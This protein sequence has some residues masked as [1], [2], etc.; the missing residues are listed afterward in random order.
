MKSFLRPALALSTLSL[1]VYVLV[2]DGDVLPDYPA[3]RRELLN[4]ATTPESRLEID[5]RGERFA[6]VHYANDPSSSGGGTRHLE[7]IQGHI[8]V[9]LEPTRD[10]NVYCDLLA[11]LVDGNVENVLQ[12]PIYNGCTVVPS[13]SAIQAAGN[14]LPLSGSEGVL[15]VE[16]D[17]LVEGY[18]GTLW[19]LDRIGQCD[20]P[21]DGSYTTKED[22]TGVKV[23][24]MDSGVR[25]DHQEFVGM[26]DPGDA[27]H[28][29]IVDYPMMP[30]TDGNGHG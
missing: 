20:L 5:E 1:L 26:I 18:Q 21:L 17:G 29:S 8:L 15:A 2:L 19:N 23:F 9:R 24:I 3:G 28:Y 11:T 6:G 22:A 10:P 16:E 13:E 30:L 25:G 4:S 27:C 7:H 12:G 14:G